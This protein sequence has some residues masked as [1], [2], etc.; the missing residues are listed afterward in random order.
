MQC[1]HIVNVATFILNASY[2]CMSN[3]KVIEIRNLDTTQRAKHGRMC[4]CVSCMF[5]TQCRNYILR[6]KI[7]IFQRIWQVQLQNILKIFV[8]L[9]TV[10]KH[11][12]MIFL[13]KKKD[14]HLF[15]F[16]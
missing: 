11:V 9:F 12:A 7:I 15:L 2:T 1:V 8:N 4:L 14:F 13:T 5:S 10:R 16:I 3:S 6:I